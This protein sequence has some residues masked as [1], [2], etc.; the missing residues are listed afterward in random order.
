MKQIIFILALLI[1]STALSVGKIPKKL[2][3]TY[4]GSI[5]EYTIN[6]NETNLKI[7]AT[8]LQIELKESYALIR[9]NETTYNLELKKIDKNK[10]IYSF[11]ID[12]PEDTNLGKMSFKLDKKTK[13]IIA[14]GKNKVPEAE[15]K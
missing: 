3:K 9:F 15:L 12:F 14:K 8:P 10:N 7:D 1:S 11:E 6:L 13:I 5:P 2:R 4:S